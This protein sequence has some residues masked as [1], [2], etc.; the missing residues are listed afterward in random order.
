MPYEQPSSDP[1]AVV[2]RVMESAVALARAEAALALAHI[3]SLWVKT[4]AALLAVIVATSAAQVVLLLLALFP[5]L[6]PT[7]TPFALLIA[8]VVSICL[9][10]LGSWL[11]LAAWRGLQTGRNVSTP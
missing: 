10:G 11:A 7:T 4:V 9:S 2:A 3:R 1:T 8:L 5:V 6:C